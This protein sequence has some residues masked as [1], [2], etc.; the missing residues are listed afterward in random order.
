MHE[1]IVVGSGLAGLIVAVEQARRGRP[2]TVLAD[3]RAP[4]GHFAGMTVDGL[5]FDV[6]MVLF[7]QHQPVQPCET[8]ADYR[9]AVRNDWTRFGHLA[10]RWLADQ[11]A[12][13]RAPTPEC[14]LEGRVAPDH[15]IANRLDVFRGMDCE[16]P[17]ALPRDDPRH[18]ARK[19]EPGPYDQLSYDEAAAW[20]H[21]PVLHER[22]IE[23]FVR[24]LTGGGSE[25][26]LA[27][28]HRAAWAPLYH[29]QTLADALAGSPATLPEYPF[30]TTA[31]G[32]VADWVRALTA[33]LA[34]RPHARVVPQPLQSLRVDG[35]GVDATTADGRAWQAR[36]TVLALG[37]ERC[38]RLLG[39]PTPDQTPS[40]SVAVWLC[41]VPAAH[42]GRLP[43]CLM[44]V[45]EAQAIYRI[46]CP[47]RLCGKVPERVRLAVEFNPD[48]MARLHPDLD[49]ETAVRIELQE[50]LGLRDTAGLRVHRQLLARNSLPLPTTGTL[51]A[52]DANHAALRERAPGA[53]PSGTLLGYGVASIND[54]IV[55]ALQINEALPP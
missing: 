4:G 21:G 42:L 47:D 36:H 6:G 13:Q 7:E 52:L 27:R 50:V 41:S 55:Q 28:Q 49:V 26:F 32:C 33:E 8:L 53:W 24:K 37:V 23:P 39:L 44:I 18:A 30:W 35:T 10:G 38:A 29:P 45:D 54:Q 48:V 2:V 1:L 5:Q 25:R 17:A 31:S 22:C 43:G 19:L 12:L 40:V 11:V 16:A 34:A 15:L 51:A 9:P 46:T 14:L 3:G 20:N